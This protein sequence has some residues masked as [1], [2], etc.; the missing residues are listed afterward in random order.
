MAKTTKHGGP[1]DVNDEHDADEARR[2]KLNRPM[3]GGGPKLAGSNSSTST[4]KRPQ[5]FHEA[6]HNP[7]QPAQT[8]ENPSETEEEES[9]TVPSTDGNTRETAKPQSG[10]AKKAGK[11]TGRKASTRSTTEDVDDEWEFDE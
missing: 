11:S 2:I 7:P 3:V 10:K 5:T 6:K 9:S 1:S 4:E 8:T